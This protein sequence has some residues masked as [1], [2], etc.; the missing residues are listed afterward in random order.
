[1]FRMFISF[2][3]HSEQRHAYAESCKPTG[4]L[5]KG[6]RGRVLRKCPGLV[7]LR[8]VWQSLVGCWVRVTECARFRGAKGGGLPGVYQGGV[9]KSDVIGPLKT[10][11]NLSHFLFQG[12]NPPIPPCSSDEIPLKSPMP[13][14]QL[15]P[16][17]PFACFFLFSLSRT[18]MF[19]FF[20][21]SPSACM[22]MRTWRAK[23]KTDKKQGPLPFAS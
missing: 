23:M 11:R 13:T 22:N 16:S 4:R 7:W 15:P 17:P 3:L 6:K 14:P 5:Q 1:M 9:T 21:Q 12:F 10:Q 2:L 19:S 18:C 8:S 20:I